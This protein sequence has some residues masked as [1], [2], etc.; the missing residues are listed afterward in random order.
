[1]TFPLDY[2][3]HFVRHNRIV[4]TAT[5]SSWGWI[6]IA[7]AVNQSYARL[8]NYYDDK[9][10]MWTAAERAA[11]ANDD[12]RHLT[13]E[14][15]LMN[16]DRVVIDELQLDIPRSVIAS[17]LAHGI[18][19]KGNRFFFENDEFQL[20]EADIAELH[21]QLHDRMMAAIDAQLTNAEFMMSVHEWNQKF[22][23]EIAAEK[24]RLLK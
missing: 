22:A 15:D 13:T 19:D 7:T 5:W 6:D 1:M 14:H 23:A 12:G 9:E 20:C 4:G 17:R 2:S 21:A 24:K 10:A 18:P 3:V 11:F 8:I 16:W